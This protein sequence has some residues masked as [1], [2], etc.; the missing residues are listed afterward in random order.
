MSQAVGTKPQPPLAPVDGRW[1]DGAH[2]NRANHPWR[3][4][5]R[6][7]DMVTPGPAGLWVLLDEDDRSINDAAFAVA[8]SSPT[9]M[10][11]WP[12]TYHEM[13][14]GLAFAD[15]H[16]EIHKWKDGRTRAVRLTRHG[17]IQTNSVDIVWLQERTSAKFPGNE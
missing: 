16:S 15:G 5:G 6:Y 17:L 8:M 12:A 1:L 10:I 11:D 4:Y 9:K 7:A 3:T 2:K 14:C 13:G